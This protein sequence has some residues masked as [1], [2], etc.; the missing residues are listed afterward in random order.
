MKTLLLLMAVS[1]VL[2]TATMVWAAPFCAC[3]K[4]VAGGTPDSY[5]IEGLGTFMP[6]TTDIQAQSDG[7][8]RIDLANLPQGSYTIRARAKN[9]WGV[10]EWSDPFQFTPVPP[11]TKPTGLKLSGQ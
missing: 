2:M 5:N 1:L 9:L 10:S 7:N 3:T 8:F 4:G 11:P 6:A